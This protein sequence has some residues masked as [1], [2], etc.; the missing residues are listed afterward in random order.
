LSTSAPQTG[1]QN[2]FLWTNRAVS[3]AGVVTILTKKEFFQTGI[4]ILSALKP[5]KPQTIAFEPMKEISVVEHVIRNEV[6][7]ESLNDH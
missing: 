5:N 3:F 1:L 7:Y 6:L 4:R 2:P